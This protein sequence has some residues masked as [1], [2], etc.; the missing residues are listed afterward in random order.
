M[1]MEIFSLRGVTGPPVFTIIASGDAYGNDRGS[2][3]RGTNQSAQMGNEPKLN[4]KS[5]TPL[6]A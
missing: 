2:V 5:V 4:T 6:V 1:A 3:S